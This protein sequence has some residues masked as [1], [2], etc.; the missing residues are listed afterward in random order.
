LGTVLWD[1]EVSIF[2]LPPGSPSTRVYAWSHATEGTKRHFVVMLHAPHVENPT[3]A[4]QQYLVK[5]SRE[6]KQGR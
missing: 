3:Q 1:G 4:V 5:V 6:A 2:D